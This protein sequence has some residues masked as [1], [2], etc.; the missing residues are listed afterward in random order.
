MIE[1]WEIENSSQIARASYNDEIDE[2]TIVFKKGTV[3]KYFN[4]SYYVFTELLD[5]KSAGSYFNKNI[6][7]KFKYKK[8]SG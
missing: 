3:Y 5:A 6:A 7:K 2:L 8:V 4:V 1:E